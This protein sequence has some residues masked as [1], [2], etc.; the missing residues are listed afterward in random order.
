MEWTEPKARKH[1][2]SQRL[3]QRNGEVHR[4]DVAHAD[5][6]HLC[7][8]RGPEHGAFAAL[9]ATR[10]GPFYAARAN[11]TWS[12]SAPQRP[13][14]RPAAGQFRQQSLPA[15][16]RARGKSAEDAGHFGSG[17]FRRVSRDLI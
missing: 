6:A 7:A 10:A 13:H 4:A 2:Q 3:H 1:Q 9:C 8:V 17:H 15:L 5:P 11:R 16:G 12:K 14:S